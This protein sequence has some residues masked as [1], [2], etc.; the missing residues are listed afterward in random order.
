MRDILIRGWRLGI[1]IGNLYWLYSSIK[2]SSFLMFALWIIGIGGSFYTSTEYEYLRTK[3]IFL[4]FLY[5]LMG[6]I[7]L[8]FLIFGTPNWILEFLA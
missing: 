4:I 2:L 5:M 1:I 3:D 8:W 6:Y 7:G